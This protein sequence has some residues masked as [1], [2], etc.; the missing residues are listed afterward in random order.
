VNTLVRRL[1]RRA[2]EYGGLALGNAQALVH[3]EGFV[4]P[5]E[6]LGALRAQLVGRPEVPY[7]AGISNS[8]MV[9]LGDGYLALVKNNTYHFCRECGIEAEYGPEHRPARAVLLQVRLDASLKVTSVVPLRVRRRGVLLEDAEDLYEDAR[10]VSLQDT[11]WVS[12]NHVPKGRQLASMPIIGRL[13]PWSATM[14]VIEVPLPGRSPPQKNWIPF[15][16]GDKLYLQY[17]VNPHVVYEVDPE[18]GAPG[19]SYSTSFWSPFFSLRGPFFRGGTP[20]VPFEDG[21]LGVAHSHVFRGEDRHYWSYFY[22]VE[23]TPPFAIRRFGIPVK[24]LRRNRIQFASALVHDSKR[25]RLVLSCGVD[26]CDNAFV[27]LDPRTI[28]ETMR[29]VGRSALML[30]RQP[31]HDAYAEVSRPP[32]NSLTNS[33]TPR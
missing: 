4:M 8:G 7:R 32:F 25:E 31:T 17:S 6:D 9:P 11:I 29:S 2:E 10:L 23:P 13:D 26:D 27:G 3:G 22:V 28:R 12:F 16:V 15:G 5:G 24:L 14:H 18:S 33:V 21:L 1:F 19:R 20:L 30:K